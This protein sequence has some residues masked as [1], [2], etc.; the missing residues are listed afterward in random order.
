[1]CM[2]AKHLGMFLPLTSWNKFVGTPVEVPLDD[3]DESCLQGMRTY[4]IITENICERTTQQWHSHHW[5]WRLNLLMEMFHSVPGYM[6]TFTI[7]SRHCIKMRQ[8]SE[9]TDS[10]IF[11]I[12]VK[13]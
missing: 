13:Q 8:I 9:D 3:A 6:T 11:F 10:F 4:Q 12:L 5:V 7:F 1:M 2:R